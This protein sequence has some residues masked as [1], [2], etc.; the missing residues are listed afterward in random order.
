MAVE[1]HA[2][3]K[4]L[5]P[6]TV[7]DTFLK[8]FECLVLELDDFPATETDQVIVMPFSR[9]GLISCLPVREF[10]FLCEP[11]AGEKFKRSVDRGVSDLGIDPRDERINLG[12]ILVARRAEKNVEDLFP[13]FGRLQ[14][15]VGDGGFELMR[16]NGS[17]LN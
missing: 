12:E 9:D 14:A 8:C 10:A 17:L 15:S 6:I 16:S 3:V 7:G 5:K 2:V 1:L 4:D 11:Q 13:L